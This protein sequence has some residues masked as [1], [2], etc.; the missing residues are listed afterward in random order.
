MI[1]RALLYWHRWLPILVSHHHRPEHS[2]IDSFH[3]SSDCPRHG[4]RRGNGDRCYVNDTT[5]RA[6]TVVFI[7]V[8]PFTDTFYERCGCGWCMGRIVSR[9]IT[10]E[11]SWRLR[12][13]SEPGANHVHLGFSRYRMPGSILAAHERKQ[14]RCLDVYG[15]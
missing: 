9:A 5:D 1:R 2:S 11:H 13:V 3:S 6:S 14:R 7:V 8:V 15:R 4:C 12:V 10:G